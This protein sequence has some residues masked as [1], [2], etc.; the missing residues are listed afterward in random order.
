MDLRQRKRLLNMPRFNFGDDD[1][2]QGA[3]TQYDPYQLNLKGIGPNYKTQLAYDV[4]GMIGSNTPLGTG[5]K[6]FG[7]KGTTGVSSNK[8]NA[9]I[10]KGAGVAQGA[11]SMFN[12]LQSSLNVKSSEQ[13]LT[14]AGSTN[15]SVMGVNYDEQNAID[16]SQ[17][18]KEQNSKGITNTANSTITGAATGAKIGGPWGAAIG[19]VIGLGSGLFGWLGGKSRLRKRIRNAQISAAQKAQLQRSSAMTTGLQNQYALRFGD[20]STGILY[21]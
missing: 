7:S 5:E 9:A 11:L 2:R 19:G 21:S 20:T 14:E 1:I 16:G 4:S 18:L 8:F 12:G 17:D 3:T 10:G 15:K 13:L 6:H